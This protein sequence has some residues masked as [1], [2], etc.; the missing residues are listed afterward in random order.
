MAIFLFMFIFSLFF[1]FF[2]RDSINFDEFIEVD[3]VTTK[4]KDFFDIV[5]IIESQSNVFV[6]SRNGNRNQ[7]SLHEY[8]VSVF[9]RRLSFGE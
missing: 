8:R 2:F 9:H 4:N 7:D 1:K 5:E 6:D 3:I